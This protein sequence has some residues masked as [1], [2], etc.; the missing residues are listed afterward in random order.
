MALIKENLD[1]GISAN[2]WRVT[3][4][5]VDTI[6]ST[7]IIFI[8]LYVNKDA[9]RPLDTRGVTIYNEDFEKYFSKTG[10][11]NFN[12]LYEASY[13]CLKECDDFFSD[14]VDDEEELAKL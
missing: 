4:V 14:A 12:D 1:F 8:G 2:Y 3:N 10:I 11:T 5:S 7:S 13:M 9:Q 6:S